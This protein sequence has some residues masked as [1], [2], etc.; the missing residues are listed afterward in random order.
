MIFDLPTQA[1]D[2]QQPHWKK[3]HDISIYDKR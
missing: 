2:M 3:I 1:Q